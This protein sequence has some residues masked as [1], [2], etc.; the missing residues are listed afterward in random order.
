MSEAKKDE[1]SLSELLCCPFCGDQPDLE[2]DGTFIEI[3]C[4]VSMS[5]QKS[6]YLS[7]KER[8]SWNSDICRFGLY[9]EY[10]ALCAVTEEWNTRAT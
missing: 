3:N 1:S 2:T 4:C 8:E 7:L 9:E 10:K 5:R 6:D